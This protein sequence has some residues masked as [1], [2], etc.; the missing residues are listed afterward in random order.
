MFEINDPI[1]AFFGGL[2]I[3]FH[4]GV[5][6]CDFVAEYFVQ[7]FVGALSGAMACVYFLNVQ[8]AETFGECYTRSSDVRNKWNPPRMA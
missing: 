3:N 4:A 6:L 8:I 7:N 2:H 5:H 1:F